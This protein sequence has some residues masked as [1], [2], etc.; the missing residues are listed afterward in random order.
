MIKHAPYYLLLKLE[1]ILY[2]FY[3]Q[4]Y[5]FTTSYKKQYLL[6]KVYVAQN[7]YLNKRAKFVHKNSRLF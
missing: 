2:N 3:E 6:Q 4:K 7:L 1:I 5:C